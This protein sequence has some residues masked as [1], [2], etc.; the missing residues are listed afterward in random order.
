MRI[1]RVCTESA[2]PHAWWAR[3]A[4][5]S[6]R[7]ALGRTLVE[8]LDL[9]V[10]DWMLTALDGVQIIR[11]LRTAWHKK[12]STRGGSRRS[13][14]S[15]TTSRRTRRPPTKGFSAK[16][17]R[18]LARRIQFV[19]TPVHGSWPTMAEIGLWVLVRPCLKLKLPDVESLC[20]EV[21]T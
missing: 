13:G 17:A 11:R 3:R 15:W 2:A 1:L 21:W 14:W 5:R 19:Y 16:V 20:E 4:T 7:S 12:G 8:R 6:G 9:L 10:V 18:E